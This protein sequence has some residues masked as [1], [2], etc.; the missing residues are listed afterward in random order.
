MNFIIVD[1]SYYTFYRYFAMTNWWSLAKPDEELVFLLKMLTLLKSLSV[2]LF[3][4]SKKC[5][6]VKN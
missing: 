4:S 6:K 5:K 2:H 1:G 3:Q